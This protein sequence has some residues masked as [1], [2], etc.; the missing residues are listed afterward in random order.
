MLETEAIDFHNH[1][2]PYRSLL[3]PNARYDYRTHTL[4]PLTQNDLN[5]LQ[6]FFRSGGRSTPIFSYSHYRQSRS[7]NNGSSR[8]SNG[9]NNRTTSNR[10]RTTTTILTPPQNSNTPAVSSSSSSDPVGNNAELSNSYIENAITLSANTGPQLSQ[11]PSRSSSSS[12]STTA[13][14]VTSNQPFPRV[15]YQ[16]NQDVSTSTTFKMK[17]KSL[18]NDVG[19]SISMRLSNNSLLGNSIQSSSSN[20]IDNNHNNGIVSRSSTIL[21]SSVKRKSQPTITNIKQMPE[22]IL[23]YIFYLVDCKSDYANCLHTCKLFYHMAKPYF[24][25]NLSFTS[26]YR[27]AQF[28]SYLRLNA[29]VG[30]YVKLID[31][32]GIKPGYDED[33]EENNDQEEEVVEAINEEGETIPLNSREVSQLSKKKALAG[34]RDWKFKNNPLYTVHPYPAGHLTK[35]ASNSQFSI[36]SNRSNSSQKSS[37]TKRFTKPFKYF[38]TR[39][40]SRSF[41]GN[42]NSRKA[43]KLETLNLNNRQGGG[44]SPMSNPHPLINKFLL[45]YS[46]SKD[47]PIGYVLHLINLCPNVCSLNLGGLS[48]STDY[49]ISRSSMCKYQTFDL[50]NNYPKNLLH[51]IDNSMKSDE[52][53]DVSSID[54]SLLYNRY[55]ENRFSRNLFKSNQTNTST[56]SSIYSV[57]TFSKPIR[58]Y[59]SLLPPLPPTLAD[60]SYVKKGDRRVY[61]SDLNL[62]SI[63]NAYLRKIDER[64]VLLAIS[65]IHGK[66]VHPYKMQQIPGLIEEDV[67]GN[68]RYINLSSMIWLNRDLI[69]KFLKRLLVKRSFDLASYGYCGPDEFD[70]DSDLD[71]DSDLESVD[72]QH[73]PIAYKQDLVIDLS[74]SGMYKNL[75]WAKRIDLNTMEG[76]K[77][78]DKIIRNEL[79]TP[80]EEFM[81]R[82]RIRRGRIGENYLA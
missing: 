30:H 26:T 64:E 10:S 18:L 5:F 12:L 80:H 3:N 24:Y 39:K 56:A 11:P 38:K 23:D 68:L 53:D 13:A 73:N 63:N 17:Y 15:N 65:R 9:H 75:L 55:P 51:K 2:P 59:N 36:S 43:P 6:S 4:I 33:A 7:L 32:S 22:E 35:I 60:I 47:V 70:D 82:E 62:K 74:N 76:C 25:E 21:S 34:W 31:L 69:E 44:S 37:S 50:M 66:Q 77:L 40:R 19:R 49:E 29:S 48:L 20:S 28:I 79:L 1:L 45:N 14:S 52:L 67:A 16:N 42:L 81:R 72:D 71:F 61:L 46:T 57:T 8:G 41:S 58:K 27:F 78:A 54:A